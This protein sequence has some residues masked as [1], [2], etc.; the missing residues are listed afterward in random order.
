MNKRK[1]WAVLLSAALVLVAILAATDNSS[2]IAEHPN[3]AKV[4][5]FVS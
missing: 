1:Q 5:F 4:T 3:L 2:S